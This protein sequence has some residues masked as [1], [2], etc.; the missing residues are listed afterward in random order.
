MNDYGHTYRSRYHYFSSSEGD[1]AT[2][3]PEEGLTNNPIND[4]WSKAEL[5]RCVRTL[6]SHD[7]G[8]EDPE[9]FYTYN[10]N[11]NTFDLGGIKATRN[12]TEE[13]LEVHNEIEPSNNL[14][15]GFVKQYHLYRFFYLPKREYSI[16]SHTILSLARGFSL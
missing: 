4:S 14:Y 9:R 11:Y 6:E 12:Y 1:K 16:T 10:E 3:W 8:V 5:V 7:D 13:P 15:S 2:F